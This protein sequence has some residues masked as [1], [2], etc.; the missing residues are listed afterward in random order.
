M[1][2][3]IILLSIIVSVG[4][5][6]TPPAKIDGL[7]LYEHTARDPFVA[8]NKLVPE[9]VYLKRVEEMKSWLYV[10]TNGDAKLSTATQAIG[11]GSVV[12]G[13]MIGAKKP[14]QHYVIDEQGDFVETDQAEH[15]RYLVLEKTLRLWEITYA[16]FGA[17]AL[18]RGTANR[19]NQ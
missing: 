11:V 15:Y 12:T 14:T 17:L 9:R 3:L 2:F 10:K 18:K 6:A 4:N 19:E 5:A 1:P 16:P 7:F 8:V 13:K